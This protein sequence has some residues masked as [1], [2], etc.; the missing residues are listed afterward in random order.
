[1]LPESNH[2]CAAHPIRRFALGAVALLTC[3]PAAAEVSESLEYR[4]Y[5]VKP[6]WAESLARSVIKATPIRENGKPY[7]GHTAWT[8]KWDMQWD[9]QPNGSCALDRVRTHLHWIITLPQVVL[10]DAEDQARF[11][12]FVKALRAHELDHVGFARDAARAIDRRL[13]SMPSMPTCD[14]L[15]DAANAQGQQQLDVARRRGVEYDVQTQHGK[16]QGAM[17]N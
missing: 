1:M 5:N 10:S 6:H 11:D 14:Q 13:Q 7:M 2:P 16:T 15:E 9:K 4:Y 17:L 8:V 3:L 12:D